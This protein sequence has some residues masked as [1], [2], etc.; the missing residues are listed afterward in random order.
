[1][2]S[3]GKCGVPGHNA[4]TCK[5]DGSIPVSFEKFEKVEHGLGMMWWYHTCGQ[6]YFFDA[7][8]ADWDPRIIAHRKEC[9]V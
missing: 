6:G 7:D 5:G 3:C 4:R 1:M 8:A 2:R 9:R